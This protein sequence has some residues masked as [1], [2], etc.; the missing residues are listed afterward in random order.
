ME[1]LANIAIR[2]RWTIF[3]MVLLLSAFFGYQL[4]FLKV[5]SNIVDSLPKDDTVVSL[6]NEVGQRFGGN[7]MGMIILE[8]QNVLDPQVLND[9]QRITDSLSEMN[10]ILSVTSLTN[11]MNIE[12]EGDNFEVGKLIN[13]NNWPQNRQQADSLRKVV[14]ANKMVAGNIISTDGTATIIL[15]TFQENDDVHAVSQ[16]IMD[17]VKKMNLTEKYYFGG[18]SFLT[19]YVADVISDDLIRLIPISFLL[20]SVILFM[21]FRS[22]RGVVL[23]IL[24]A[25][26]AILWALGIFVMLGMK[27]SMVS[28]NVPIII[29][30]VGSA[31]A[32]HV[33][34]RINQCKEKNTRMA[35]VKA[36]S[37]MIVPVA[38]TALTTMVGFLSF[39]FGAYLKM[40]RDFGLLAAMGTF[41]AAMFALVFVPAMI[42]IFPA[43][44]KKGGG[45]VSRHE[46][47]IMTK[48]I[49][50]PLSRMV[51]KKRYT[52]VTVWL[53]LFAVS[54]VGIF[55]IKRSVD[56]SDYFKP[57]YPASVAN[58]IMAEKFGG[59][60][61]VFVVFKG[62]MQSPEVLKRMLD[63]EKYMKNSPYISNTQSIADVVAKLN[64]AMGEGNV[65][66]GDEA[67]IQQLWFLIGQ[68]E[69][70][71]RL[72]TEDLDQGI[73]IAKFN[74]HGHND[75]KVFNDYMQKYFREHPS[76]NYSIEITGMPFVNS[77]LD[78]SLLRSQLFSLVIAI[79]L[80]IIIVSLL[81][82]S[83]IKG[84]YASLPILATIAILY[85][86]MGL[87]G[88][89]LNVV[90]VLVA[91]IA[92]G[93]GIDYSIHFVSH[94]NHSIK[95]YN[96]IKTAVEE[97]MLVSGKAIMINFISVSAGFLV[98]VFSELVPMIYFGI[99]IALS[100]LGSSMGALTL[101]P[102]IILIGVRKYKTNNRV[103]NSLKELPD[104]EKQGK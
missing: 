48:Y 3:V 57:N 21:S 89:P 81:F 76:G 65:I 83:F 37:F 72:V 97:T 68:Q 47:P 29:L 1:K 74:D 45:A 102:S 27:L 75:I 2:Y 17:M 9:I 96:S 56:V 18:S 71:S 59:S 86:I 63:L 85:G 46:N 64:D 92:M 90:T 98:L 91:S 50:L 44:R 5:D 94:F 19:L 13:D 88:I 6:F 66:P 7:E 8:G 25:A 42:A 95:N 35:I 87:T 14:T 4:K 54:I 58:K 40:I 69:S 101:L 22:I 52:V 79:V 73:I 31:Y 53:L 67:K 70:V 49:L 32:I 100:M 34:N 15:F 51:I 55:M 43:K 39:I 28:N 23:P 10:G 11:I 103:N 20:I 61:P 77:Q 30:A 62:D 84:L 60:K 33:L 41:F 80:V 104:S 24:T 82:K 36:L 16:K 38:L 99:L 93:I 78:K 12:V 26:L